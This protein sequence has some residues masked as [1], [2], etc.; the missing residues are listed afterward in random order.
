MQE[1]PQHDLP[2]TEA[3]PLRRE[4]RSWTRDL[5]VALGLAAR[6]HLM[7]KTSIVILPEA[8]IRRGPYDE[9]QSFFTAPDGAE[10]L[11]LEERGDWVEVMDGSQ[12]IGWVPR[13]EL[14]L[15]RGG[16]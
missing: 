4:L 5:A 15:L 9:S 14:S 8:V 12:R 16:A 13:N 6:Q 2:S 11:V 10:F 1:T 3:A 7:G